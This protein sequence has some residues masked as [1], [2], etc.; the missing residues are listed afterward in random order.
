[1]VARWRESA[2]VASLCLTGSDRAT[3]IKLAAKLFGVEG[4][5]V[6][7]G[8]EKKQMGVICIKLIYPDF[9]GPIERVWRK[10]ISISQHDQVVTILSHFAIIDVLSEDVA[11]PKEMGG[12]V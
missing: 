2:E 4:H 1:M 6:L 9:P 11:L 7:T 8:L 10:M 5:S 12:F 3:S